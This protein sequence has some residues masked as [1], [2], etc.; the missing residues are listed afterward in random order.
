MAR[1]IE[2]T[3]EFFQLFFSKGRDFLDVNLIVDGAAIMEWT[4]GLLNSME[5]IKSR[6]NAGFRRNHILEV[7]QFESEYVVDYK[8][9]LFGYC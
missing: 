8:D 6:E 3:V 9:K 1:E 2:R 5:A 4:L 7:G